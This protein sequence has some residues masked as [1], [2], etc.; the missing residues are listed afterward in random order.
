MR[1]TAF[2]LFVTEAVILGFFA[3]DV[4]FHVIG[5]GKLYIQRASACVD[6][7]MIL[8][9]AAVLVTCLF[10]RLFAVKLML[11]I[12]LVASRFEADIKDKAD[13]LIFKRSGRI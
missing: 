6:L 5:Y 13:I 2:G 8:I 9:N 7:I 11:S 10:E 12:L 1:Q 4:F 3:F